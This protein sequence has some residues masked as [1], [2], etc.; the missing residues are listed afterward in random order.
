[1]L[2]VEIKKL[3]NERGF[4][5]NI[6]CQERDKINDMASGFSKFLLVGQ[7]SNQTDA[8]PP[9]PPLPPP[10]A[11]ASDKGTTE[12]ERVAGIGGCYYLNQERGKFR[13]GYNSREKGNCYIC[14]KPGHFATNCQTNIANIV[15]NHMELVSDVL[16][17]KRARLEYLR[18]Q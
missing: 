2:L 17:S 9:P 11:T 13:R 3:L 8:P 1:M 6:R 18:R 12:Q 7:P 5:T 10:P 14:R 15:I 4:S 16:G